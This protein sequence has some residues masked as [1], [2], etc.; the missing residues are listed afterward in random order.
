M[1][2]EGVDGRQAWGVAGE[3]VGHA[4][5][6]RIDPSSVLACSRVSPPP[7]KPAQV[8]DPVP[9]LVGRGLPAKQATRFFSVDTHPLTGRKHQVGRQAMKA[10][11]VQAHVQ[12]KA[13]QVVGQGLGRCVV[14]EVVLLEVAFTPRA[15]LG[16][17]GRLAG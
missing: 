17:Q 5:L 8:S 12:R 14:F 10:F 1:A 6:P 15:A 13:G 16:P 4:V 9:S 11:L 7:Q 2:Q 3:A